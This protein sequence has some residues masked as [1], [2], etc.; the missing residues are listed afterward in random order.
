[1]AF[2]NGHDMIDIIICKDKMSLMCLL[3]FLALICPFSVKNI[4]FNAP[5]LVN[6]EDIKEN[7]AIALYDF[8]LHILDFE[9]ELD[10][11][12]FPKEYNSFIRFKKDDFLHVLDEF[13]EDFWWAESLIT[14]AK[15]VI[16]SFLV[17]YIKDDTKNET[18][19]NYKDISIIRA[20]QDFD[21]MNLT[22]FLSY[23]KE[24]S[25]KIIKPMD[26]LG[27]IMLLVRSE[28]TGKQGIVTRRK[29]YLFNATAL[30]DFDAEIL[31]VQSRYGK[32]AKFRKG[33]SF[34]VIQ[35]FKQIELYGFWLVKHSSTSWLTIYPMALLEVHLNSSVPIFQENVEFNYSVV[36]MQSINETLTGFLSYMEGERIQMITQYSA[37]LYFSRSL[38]TGKE[39]FFFYPPDQVALDVVKALHDF[40]SS[41]LGLEDIVKAKINFKKEDKVYVKFG[42]GNGERTLKVRIKSTKLEGFV[43]AFFLYNKNL[44]L[45]NSLDFQHLNINKNLSVAIRNFDSSDLESFISYEYMEELEIIEMQDLQFWKAKKVSTGECGIIDRN[46]TAIGKAVALF[47]YT[48]TQDDNRTFTIRRGETYFLLTKIDENYWLSISDL[49]KGSILELVLL[50]VPFSFDKNDIDI[51]IDVKNYS[52]SVSVLNDFDGNN[53]PGFLS[54]RV[55]ETI[56]I[57]KK[58]NNHTWLVFSRKANKVGLMPTFL[59]ENPSKSFGDTLPAL[60]DTNKRN[61]LNF[62]TE[63]LRVKR[64]DLLQIEKTLHPEIWLATFESKRGY[65]LIRDVIDTCIDGFVCGDVCVPFKRIF[66]GGFKC[67]C[68]N[69]TIFPFEDSFATFCC[70]H[71][72]DSCIEEN[73]DSVIC[74]GG[75]IQENLIPCH[76]TCHG[77]Y[78]NCLFANTFTC[79]NSN[80]ECI[81]ASQMCQG[82]DW[83]GE[84]EYCNKD[85]LCNDLDK[86]TAMNYIKEGKFEFVVSKS[87]V[88]NKQHIQTNLISEHHFCKNNDFKLIKNKMYDWLDRS[89]EKITV[90][91]KKISRIDFSYVHD[92]NANGLQGK[93]CYYNER[94]FVCLSN[95]CIDSFESVSCLV[96][97]NKTFIQTNDGQLCRNHTFWSTHNCSS[98]IYKGVLC[99]GQKQHCYTPWYNFPTGDIFKFYYSHKFNC[100]DKSD[101]IFLS[102][103]P[104]PNLKDFLAIHNEQYCDQIDSFIGEY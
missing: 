44:D 13:H 32:D 33:D 95:W 94:E 24:E 45:E 75:N 83:C 10:R 79:E 40:D 92:C 71:P 58:F 34:Y 96:G 86:N 84:T 51:D 54:F 46:N 74:A 48:S 57:V 55:G 59:V 7:V 41:I 52:A 60:R 67:Q 70:I 85:I 89:D 53:F 17:K 50:F 93:S 64:G 2:G 23:K 82:V 77:D 78:K 42:K 68:G 87:R 81:H 39:G 49:K 38:T 21:S 30:Y 43:P 15:G 27:M 16:P 62:A 97:E 1:M 5:A 69:G 99:N 63:F 9:N 72:K 76:G 12:I 20:M 4:F 98:R 66:Q 90:S 47:D 25:F 91:Q 14:K 31:K 104:C 8:D 35:K 100:D 102:G 73:K 3:L 103:A 65:I 19:E 26:S 28:E 37:D 88:H 61:F 101:Q 36:L 6:F 80:N 29:T 56:E 18:L 22:G 11:K